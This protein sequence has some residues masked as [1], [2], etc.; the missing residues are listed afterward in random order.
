MRNIGK[1]RKWHI[2]A[3]ISALSVLF[4]CTDYVLQEDGDLALR[5]SKHTNEELTIS[6]AKQ[7]FESNYDP[8]VATRSVGGRERLNK[9]Y[10]EKAKEYNR[11]RYEVVE[12]PVLTRG[13]H[14]I[15]D[16]ETATHWQPGMKS[17]IIRNTVRMVVLRDKKTE[18]TRS[19]I[20]TFVGTYDYLKKTRTIGKNSYLYREPDFSG[21][22]LFHELDGRFINGWRYEDGKIVASLSSSSGET[23]AKGSLD[24]TTRA[25][26][27]VCEETCYAHYEN[28]CYPEYVMVGGDIESGFIYD[29]EENCSLVYTGDDCTMNCQWIDDG[30]GEPD[31]NWWEEDY[32]PGGAGGG[33]TTPTDPPSAPCARA[34]S[35]SK[36]AVLVNWVNEIYGLTYPHKAG[37]TE[38]GFIVT[39]TGEIIR[40]NIKDTGSVLFENTQIAG[41]QFVSWYHSHPGGGSAITSLGDLKTL[42]TRYQQGYITSKNFTYGVVS[43]YGCLSIMI[44]SSADFAKFATKLKNLEFD[45]YWNKNIDNGSSV[46]SYGVKMKQL[47]DFF[48]NKQAGL[49]VFFRPMQDENLSNNKEDWKA[50][51]LDD[52]NQLID[53][54]CN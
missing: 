42:A 41:R 10:W 38:Q 51:D 31:D 8:V 29:I 34:K 25:L 19:F 21:A 54:N 22:V 30:S 28:E 32:P 40:P 15:I 6:A 27:E 53:I 20:M 46:S 7:W 4:A 24:A 45:D 35:L 52:S 49:S 23:P 39:S 48:N 13:T 5:W 33:G 3:C 1:C 44:S 9:P 43:Y 50:K 47:V 26:V 17:N 36:D 18:K 12:T 37:N 11:R 14:I 16:R 2:L